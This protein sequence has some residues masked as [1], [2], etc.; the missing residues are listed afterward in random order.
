VKSGQIPSIV[1][2]LGPHM[3]RLLMDSTRPSPHKVAASAQILFLFLS[4]TYLI[5]IF[6]QGIVEPSTSQDNY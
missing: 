1:W 4:V 6:T 3:D 5:K 2:T